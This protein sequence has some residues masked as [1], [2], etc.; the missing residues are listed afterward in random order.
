MVNVWYPFNIKLGGTQNHFGKGKT[1]ATGRN[2]API[3]RS[4]ILYILTLPTE[5]SGIGYE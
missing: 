5:Q 3:N 4:P 1:L 2:H